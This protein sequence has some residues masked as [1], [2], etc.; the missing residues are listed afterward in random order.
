M[1]DAA[2][3]PRAKAGQKLKPQ[4]SEKASGTKNGRPS[5]TS[6]SV[7]LARREIARGSWCS[8]QVMMKATILISGS[9]RSRA[10][11]RGVGTVKNLVSASRK[12]Y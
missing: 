8:V 9:V 6:T 3:K 12:W 10:P 7:S 11:S 2:A 1:S 5:G 4:L